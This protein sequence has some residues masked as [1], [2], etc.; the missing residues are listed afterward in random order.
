MGFRF[1][2]A[3]LLTSALSTTSSSSEIPTSSGTVGAGTETSTA[4]GYS[5]IKGSSC[6]TI[7]STESTPITTSATPS[8]TMSTE[9][10]LSVVGTGNLKLCGGI[11]THMITA[12]PATTICS[13]CMELFYHEG[14]VLSTPIYIFGGRHSFCRRHTRLVLGTTTFQESPPAVLRARG[15]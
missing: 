8:C 1:A 5:T 2:S 6:S 7:A 12:T 11:T 10:V 15:S 14:P 13:S 3:T 4:T 9:D